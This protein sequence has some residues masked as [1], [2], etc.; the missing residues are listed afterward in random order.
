LEAREKEISL[1]LMVASIFA[2]GASMI[3]RPIDYVINEKWIFAADATVFAR[4]GADFRLDLAWRW[5]KY[6]FRT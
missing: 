1:L 2:D 6:A 3:E 5:L 4:F